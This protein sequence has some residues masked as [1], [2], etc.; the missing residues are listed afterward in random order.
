LTVKDVI[1]T[2][3][4]MPPDTPIYITD[5]NEGY[6]WPK[7]I[8]SKTLEAVNDYLTPDD[9]VFNKTTRGVFLG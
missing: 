3:S 5:W 7:E 2:L 1:D 4:K 8:D 6:E 9:R